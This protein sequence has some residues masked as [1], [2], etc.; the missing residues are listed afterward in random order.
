MTKNRPGG[1]QK[2]DRGKDRLE[3]MRVYVQEGDK[4][5]RHTQ[6]SLDIF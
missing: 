2:F 1:R 4:K 6:V 5:C 3:A